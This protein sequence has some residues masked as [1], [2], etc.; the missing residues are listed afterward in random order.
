MDTDAVATKQFTKHLRRM[1]L[2]VHRH[3]TWTAFVIASPISKRL[4]SVSDV[5]VSTTIPKYSM[6]QVTSDD[7]VSDKY[8]VK[9][10]LQ[11]NL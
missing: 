1:Y 4:E 10:M 9:I 3:V 2:N 5:P 6:V 7:I 8:L 11:L